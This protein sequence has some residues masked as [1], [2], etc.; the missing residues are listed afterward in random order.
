MA[1]LE[2]HIPDNWSSH[3]LMSPGQNIK[4][5]F[6]LCGVAPCNLTNTDRLF[7]RGYCLHQSDEISFIIKQAERH[8]V[9]RENHIPIC[10]KKTLKSLHSTVKFL[11][12]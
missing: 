1:L 4:N 7:V 3:G 5:M 2:A 11:S 12:V 9:S 8:V 10:H 6:I